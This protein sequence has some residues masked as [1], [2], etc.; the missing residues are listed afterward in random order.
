MSGW[1]PGKAI[2]ME[3]SHIEEGERR[4]ARQEVLV[5]Q[6][7]N[8]GHDILVREGVGISG[9]LC[10]SLRLSRDRLRDLESRYGKAPM[11]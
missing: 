1:S 9:L 10:E 3:R 8:R 2:E 4:V 7:T 11:D 6:L 5:R